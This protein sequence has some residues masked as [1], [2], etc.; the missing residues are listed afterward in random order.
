MSKELDQAQAQYRAGDYKRA[1][2]TLW[3]V[4]FLGMEAEA[5]ARSVVA[6][7]TLLRD[8]T[9]GG[10]RRDCDEH[11][12][13]AERFLA[14]GDDADERARAGELVRQSRD[15][16]VREASKA[17]AAGLGW[18]ELR[19]TVDIVA[20]EAYSAAPS[21]PSSATPRP[22]G[23]IDAVEAE[24][25]RLEHVACMFRPTTVQTSVLRGAEYFM[26]GDL[27]DGEEIH[28]YLFRASR[29]TSA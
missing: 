11:I 23:T 22:M 6:L 12:A 8:A 24:G 7:A 19:R 1:V 4:T 9:Q 28:I 25:W 27:V 16:A 20:T 14:S 21:D 2:D 18:F 17:A 5:D 26:G 15:D 10:A 3:E 29:E 13:R